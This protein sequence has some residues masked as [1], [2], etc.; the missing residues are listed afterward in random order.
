MAT[1]ISGIA[2][3][4]YSLSF[5]LNGDGFAGQVLWAAL[6]AML[7]DG[8]LRVLL[9]K[10]N[11]AGALTA[12]NADG[13]HAQLVRIRRIDGVGAPQLDPTDRQIVWAA[14]ALNVAADAG[15]IHYEMRLAQSEER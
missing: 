9:A 13:A 1:S 11:A 5:S 3:T 4:P 14:G 10:L 2:A 6:D 12:L 15:S 8:P 7:V